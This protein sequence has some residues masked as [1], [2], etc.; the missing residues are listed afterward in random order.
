MLPFN[1]YTCS[2]SGG[3]GLLDDHHRELVSIDSSMSGQVISIC[4][5]YVKHVEGA[6][7]ILQK[8]TF[9]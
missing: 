1:M 4:A 5:R 3:S 8:E 2:T 9:G 7:Y 6:D